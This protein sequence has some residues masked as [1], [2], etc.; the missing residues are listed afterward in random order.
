MVIA[1]KT[2]QPERENDKAPRDCEAQMHDL[3]FFIH[4]GDY[5]IAVKTC[6]VRKYR[7][8]G[9]LHLGAYIREFQIP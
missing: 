7:L 6:L 3:R 8:F 2:D 5:D 4:D 1:Q 9:L